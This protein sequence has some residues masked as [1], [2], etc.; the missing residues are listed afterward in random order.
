VNLAA[1]D[2][3]M[4]SYNLV[5][6]TLSNFANITLSS[7]YFDIIKD[8]LYADGVSDERRRATLFVLQKVTVHQKERLGAHLLTI[9][10]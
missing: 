4:T 7:F 2:E 3:L 9:S 1:R 8:S 6:S 5:T 10:L